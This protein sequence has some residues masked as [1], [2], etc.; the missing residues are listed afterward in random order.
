LSVISNVTGAG[1]AAAHIGKVASLDNAV[2]TFNSTERRQ[3]KTI[4]QV[5]S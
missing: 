5:R 1:V 2:G 4:I 3:G